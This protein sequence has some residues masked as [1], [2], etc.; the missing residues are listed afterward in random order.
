[1]TGTS[2]LVLIDQGA[3]ELRLP[4]IRDHYVE[5][6]EAAR[7]ENWSHA[8]LLAELLSVEISLRDTRR[9]A[10]LLAEA[11]VPRTKLLAQFD[12][13]SSAMSQDTL[14]WLARGDFVASATSVV[15]IGGPGTGK[16]HLLI[17]TLI[18][19]AGMGR[20]VRY[21]NASALVNELAEAKRREEAEPT[22]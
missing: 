17:G 5:Y 4:G 6:L 21:V 15:L 19:L 2:N 3:I 14:A 9:S 7:R 12:L 13:G 20:R 22:A 11:K 8:H 18:A 16:T 10:R 1:M